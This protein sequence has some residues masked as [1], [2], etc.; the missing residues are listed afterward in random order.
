[1]EQFYDLDMNP[2]QEVHFQD[3]R[4]YTESSAVDW[5]GEK[6]KLLIAEPLYNGVIRLEVAPMTEDC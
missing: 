5:N 4:P 3:T 2:V 6:Y 1:M